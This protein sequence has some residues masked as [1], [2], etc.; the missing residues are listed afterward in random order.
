MP[1]WR[2]GLACRMIPLSRRPAMRPA[3]QASFQS[4][5]RRRAGVGGLLGGVLVLL[6]ACTGMPDVLSRTQPATPPE[7]AAAIGSGAVKVGLI[8]PLSA[9]GNAGAV[10][11]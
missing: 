5:S 7:Q 10:G 3:F 6:A 9:G 8:L 11:Q 1:G 4:P 2:Y